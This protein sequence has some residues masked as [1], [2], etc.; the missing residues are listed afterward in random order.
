MRQQKIARLA[1]VS[2]DSNGVVSFVRT[3]LE[4]ITTFLPS[5]E[6]REDA[7][8]RCPPNVSIHELDFIQHNY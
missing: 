2:K 8:I 7:F 3:T 5:A 1:A 6:T 4:D